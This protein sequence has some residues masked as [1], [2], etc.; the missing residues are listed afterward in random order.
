MLALVGAIHVHGSEAA[1]LHRLNEQSSW[2]WYVC[3]QESS[4]Q[5]VS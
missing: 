5:G 3:R 4:K 2:P 1:V